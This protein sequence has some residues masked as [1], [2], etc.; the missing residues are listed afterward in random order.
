MSPKGPLLTHRRQIGKVA[1]V[2]MLVLSNCTPAVRPA[3][4][5]ETTSAGQ[6]TVSSQ[7]QCRTQ[8]TSSI[9]GGIDS[10]PAGADLAGVGSA[11]IPNG[12]FAQGLR[13]WVI[14]AP[15]TV[16][17]DDSDRDQGRALRVLAGPTTKLRHIDSPRFAVTPGAGYR[18]TIGARIDSGAAQL[19]AFSMVFFA[20]RVTRDLQRF[21]PPSGPPRY[22]EYTL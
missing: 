19:G 10:P 22:A 3:G 11:L 20:P 12:D 18:L 17:L 1:I 16:G 15:E 9:V 2:A 13:G 8:E 5:G 21:D 6:S 14:S 4:R 7:L